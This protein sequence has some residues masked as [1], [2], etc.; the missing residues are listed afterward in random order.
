[1]QSVGL[2]V[3]FKGIGVG[4]R[5]ALRFYLFFFIKQGAKERVILARLYFC[6]LD[7][8]A[9]LPASISPVLCRYPLFKSKFS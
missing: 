3:G 7:M 4:G 2:E 5:G 9:A 1:M 6:E 8:L